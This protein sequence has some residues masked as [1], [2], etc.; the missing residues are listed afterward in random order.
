MAKSKSP[1]LA[2]DRFCIPEQVIK[3]SVEM[4]ASWNFVRRPKKMS[5]VAIMTINANAPGNCKVSFET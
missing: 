3:K 4:N 1:E 5:E 2:A